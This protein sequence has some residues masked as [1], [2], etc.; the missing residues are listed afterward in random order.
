MPNYSYF[1]R[2]FTKEYAA[3]IDEVTSGLT[4]PDAKLLKWAFKI[5]GIRVRTIRRQNALLAA[6]MVATFF[7][8]LLIES[9]SPLYRACK[10]AWP[11]FRAGASDDEIERKYGHMSIGLYHVMG[12]A[13]V[14]ASHLRGEPE[15][16][17][18][19]RKKKG[20]GY[21]QLELF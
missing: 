16:P 12:G 1:S 3:F 18:K 14:I 19:G 6:A 9:E 10:E 2:L 5:E 15:L 8:C 13:S 21:E 17:R 20:H 11:S 4:P 7:L